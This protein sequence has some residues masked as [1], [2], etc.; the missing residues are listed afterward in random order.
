MNIAG[1]RMIEAAISNIIPVLLRSFLLPMTD[2]ILPVFVFSCKHKIDSP[3][4]TNQPIGTM[5]AP[6]G[7]DGIRGIQ[8]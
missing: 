5:Y 7:K 6:I 2:F 4:G 8:E 1:N 3:G